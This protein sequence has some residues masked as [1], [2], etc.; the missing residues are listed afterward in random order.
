MT[1]EVGNLTGNIK[2]FALRLIV[3]EVKARYKMVEVCILKEYGI[4]LQST[5]QIDLYECLGL[6]C[7]E[8]TGL[9]PHAACRTPANAIR[10]QG[11]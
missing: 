4:S 3:Q 2:N 5:G 6:P 9:A 1:P 10:N 7:I 11:M 8:V